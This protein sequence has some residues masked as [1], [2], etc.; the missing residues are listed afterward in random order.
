MQYADIFQKKN[1][2]NPLNA[3]C[4]QTV[5]KFYSQF[6]SEFKKFPAGVSWRRSTWKAFFF[7]KIEGFI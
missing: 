5:N 1:E 3:Q 4:C 6:E 2:L 7:D